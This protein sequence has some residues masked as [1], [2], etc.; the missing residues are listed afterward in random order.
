MTDDGDRTVHTTR[1][2]LADTQP[3][4][5]LG[6]R[7]VLELDQDLEVVGEAGSIAELQDLIGALHPDLVVTDSILDREYTTVIAQ[8]AQGEARRALV[9]SSDIRGATVLQLLRAGARGYLDKK[10]SGREALHAVRMVVAGGVVLSTAVLTQLLADIAQGPVQ[11]G[12]AAFPMLTS[13]ELQ[14]LDLVAAGASNRQIARRLYLSDKTIR[15]NVSNIL[16]RLQLDERAKLIVLARQA[17]LG[18]AA[19]E[20]RGTTLV[21]IIGA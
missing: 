15:N 16:T 7:G 20:E 3:M 9:I 14:I 5:R 21:K 19:T 2:L 4:F 18:R 10:T 8:A 11:A 1:V 12:R 6:L 13:R 17:G